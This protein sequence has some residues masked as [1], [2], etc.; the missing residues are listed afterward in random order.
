[1]TRFDRVAV[2]EALLGTL[3]GI[4]LRRGR[5]FVFQVVTFDLETETRGSGGEA[6]ATTTTSR[7]FLGGLTTILLTIAVAVHAVVTTT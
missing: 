4:V 2:P 7:G 6:F 3:D 5:F 1:M